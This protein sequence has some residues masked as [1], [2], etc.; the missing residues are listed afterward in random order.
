MLD[1][2]RKWVTGK[3]FRPL[4]QGEVGE[5]L[6][7]WTEHLHSQLS[8]LNKSVKTLLHDTP[9][10]FFVFVRVSECWAVRWSRCESFLFLRQFGCA[11]NGTYYLHQS[12]LVTSCHYWNCC[13]FLSSLFMTLCS[14]LCWLLSFVVDLRVAILWFIHWRHSYHLWKQCAASVEIVCVLSVLCK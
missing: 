5:K 13:S 4:R 10:S 8:E 1:F 7:H 11:I 14:L 12:D 6:R 2:H 3:N 9:L